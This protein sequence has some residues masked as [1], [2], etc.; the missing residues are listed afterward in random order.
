MTRAFHK[1]TFVASISE[2]QGRIL[3]LKLDRLDGVP[4][5]GD[6]GGGWGGE[7]SVCRDGEPSSV[8]AGEG[9]DGEVATRRAHSE[10]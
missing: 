1:S 5:G 8:D 7:G 9:S 10:A 4:G 6:C 2:V 3:V